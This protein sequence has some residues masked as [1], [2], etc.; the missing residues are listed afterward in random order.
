M[1]QT[2]WQM[3]GERGNKD[4]FSGYKVT[5]IQDE[6]SS[7]RYAIQHSTYNNTTLCTWKCTKRVGVMLNILTTKQKLRQKMNGHKETFE[8]DQYA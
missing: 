1:K 2:E 6:L 3:M 7:K 5:S 8:G 4:S